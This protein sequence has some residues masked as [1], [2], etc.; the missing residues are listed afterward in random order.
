MI[1]ANYSIAEFAV[2]DGRIISEI[3]E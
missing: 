2:F 1:E 3:L